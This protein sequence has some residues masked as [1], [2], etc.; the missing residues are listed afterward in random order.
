MA[1]TGS[2]V[3]RHL[4]LLGRPYREGGPGSNMRGLI[5]SEPTPEAEL[6]DLERKIVAA[7][8]GVRAKREAWLTDF[9]AT[10]PSEERRAVAELIMADR[11][12]PKEQESTA[13]ELVKAG[14]ALHASG[15]YL[16]AYPEA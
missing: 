9:A 15:R 14:W 12:I 2:A 8:D 11:A 1:V 16:P 7:A 5:L 6:A 3:Q 10:N 13:D 4:N